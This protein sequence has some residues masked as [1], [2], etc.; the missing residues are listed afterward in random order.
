MMQALAAQDKERGVLPIDPTDAKA[1]GLVN[2]VLTWMGKHSCYN[3]SEAFRQLEVAPASYYRA[4]KRPFVQGKIAE[5]MDA[6]D[7]AAAQIVEVHWLG[8]LANVARIAEGTGREAVQ[9]AR[10]LAQEK[11]RLQQQ[12]E[13]QKKEQGESLAAIILRQAM[14]PRSN[15]AARRTVVTEE[16]DMKTG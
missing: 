2:S 11:E 4:M 15:V 5:R 7:K 1:W 8:I 9:A 16:I 10:F 12:G 13:G 14:A 3:Y 6:L